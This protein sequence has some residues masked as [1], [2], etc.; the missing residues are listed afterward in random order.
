M[1]MAASVALAAG[2]AAAPKF[3]KASVRMV[4]YVPSEFR[5]VLGTAVNG[6]VRLTDATLQEC[7][8]FAFGIANDLQIAGPDWMRSRDYL[9][10]VTAT[11]P[12]DTPLAQLRLMLQNLLA[13]RFQ[14]A[15]HH[16]SRE[17]SFL[18]L[19]EAKGGTRLRPARAG[20][21]PSGNAQVSG[22]ISSNSMSMTQLT[23]VLSHFLELPV[24]DWTGLGGLYEVKLRWTPESEGAPL[25]RP[26][27]FSAIED[28]LG[29]SL[30]RRK[31]PLDVI[32]VDRAEK[33][34]LGN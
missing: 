27:L 3:D 34:P 14:M 17:L 18:A 33:K 16:E 24:L 10:N 13:E 7:L 6:D 1:L 20:S 12:A 5:A 19:V 11:A 15:L 21:D 30:E 4:R 26:A 28:Q 2:Q 23:T 29:L 25:V 32:V 8:R 22:N 9:Y 31:E